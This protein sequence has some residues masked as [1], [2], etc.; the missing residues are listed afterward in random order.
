MSDF[1]DNQPLSLEQLQEARELA[2]SA[3]VRLVKENAVNGYESVGSYGVM[4][5]SLLNAMCHAVDTLSVEITRRER[6]AAVQRTLRQYSP[7]VDTF[8]H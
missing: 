1:T 2:L 4:S 3:V 5:S 7:S 8:E 6:E